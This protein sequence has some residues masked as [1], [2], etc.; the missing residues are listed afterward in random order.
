MEHVVKI[1]ALVMLVYFGKRL[2]RDAVREEL[3]LKFPK[4]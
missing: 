4:L 1:L 3:D 2:I